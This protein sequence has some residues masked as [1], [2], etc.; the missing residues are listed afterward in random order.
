MTI[1][2]EKNVADELRTILTSKVLDDFPAITSYSID[3]SIYKLVPKAIVLAENEQDIFKL[4][5]YCSKNNIPI[6][7]RAGGTN[8]T[9]NAVGEGEP[10][11]AG[12]PAA[13][14]FGWDRVVAT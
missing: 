4:V 3:A 2:Q 8:L 11:C 10:G 1:L 9:G 7:G 5:S 14:C 12:G 6:T 13:G